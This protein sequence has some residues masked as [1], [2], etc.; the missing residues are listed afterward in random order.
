MNQVELNDLDLSPEAVRMHLARGQA[1]R[2]R[3]IRA[4]ALGAL[5]AVVF[6]KRPEFTT[7][8]ARA[9]GMNA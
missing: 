7:S 3:M 6:P 1:E 4:W 5:R 9:A 2:S 8:A